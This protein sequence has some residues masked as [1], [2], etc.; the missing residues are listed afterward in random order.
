MKS[1]LKKLAAA[2]NW[3]QCGGLKLKVLVLVVLLVLAAAAYLTVA[4]FRLS[5][6]EV[7]LAELRRSWTHDTICHEAC[8]AAREQAETVIARDLQTKSDSAVAKLIEKYFSDQTIDVSFKA[9][10]VRLLA[11]AVGPDNP[12]VY[13]QAYA[14]G[15]GDPA[16]QGVII[17]TFHFSPLDYYFLLLTT[18]RSL[19]LRLAAAAAIS[20]RLDKARD[21]SLSQLVIL[22]KLILASKTEKNLR[23]ALV[24]LLGDYYPLFAAP[25]TDVLLAAY[26]DTSNDDV[27]SQAWAA[28][29]LSRLAHLKV[30]MPEVGESAWDEY[31]NN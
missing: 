17:Q 7:K 25:T 15:P 1:I 31:Y 26:H 10:L 9:E 13:L 11:Q 20:N 19:T 28:D 24:L 3:L 18:N 5:P 2:R 16:L 23:S 27:V 21:F 6:A 29:L 4:M 8:A 30:K 22:K 12:P 14:A